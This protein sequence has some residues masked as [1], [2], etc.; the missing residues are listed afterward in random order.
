MDDGSLPAGFVLDESAPDP[1]A[2][3]QPSGVLRITIGPKPLQHNGGVPGGSTGGTGG[4]DH[5]AQLPDGFVLDEEPKKKPGAGE[6]AL[7]GAADAA[8]FGTA[9]IITG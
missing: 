5:P 7:R 9:P 8:S 6:A 1:I 4:S 3:V 2:Q